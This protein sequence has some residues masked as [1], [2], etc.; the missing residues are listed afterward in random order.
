MEDTHIYRERQTYGDGD[1]YTEKQTKTHTGTETHVETH[2]HQKTHPETP[3]K[4]RSQRG[5]LPGESEPQRLAEMC[6]GRQKKVLRNRDRDMK[7]E[8]ETRRETEKRMH[9][10]MHRRRERTVRQKY[11]LKDRQT[12]RWPE[13]GRNGGWVEGGMDGYMGR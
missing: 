7:T 9:T 4:K 3:T 10:D 13:K 12:E 8:S 6:R 5:T 11:S 1:T 2:A